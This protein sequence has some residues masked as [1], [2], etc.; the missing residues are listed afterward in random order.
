[1][2]VELSAP[3]GQFCH[4]PAVYYRLDAFKRGYPLL[5]HSYEEAVY[6]LLTTHP[7]FRKADITIEA[8]NAHQERIGSFYHLTDVP[9]W[10]ESC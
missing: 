9:Y 7:S 8:L 2:N 4:G 6:Y 1:M 5:F 10:F 3:E